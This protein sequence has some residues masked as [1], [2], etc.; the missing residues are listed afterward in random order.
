MKINKLSIIPLSLLILVTSCQKEE[1]E[2]VVEDPIEVCNSA[3]QEAYITEITPNN[4]QAYTN[5]IID[6]TPSQVWE[7]MTDF[8][9]M[10]DWSTTLQGI[11]GDVSNGGNA[12]IHFLNAGTVVDIPH[13]LIYEDGVMF[14][15]SEETSSAPGIFDH[16]IYKVE[17]CGDQT[18]FIQ[19]DQFVGENASTSPAELAEF[20]V[21]FY[22]IFNEDLKAEV[23]SRF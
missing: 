7:V 4:A 18:K 2:P 10:P 23:E 17:A 15:W 21:S 19:S 14:G 5:I 9:T 8:A 11:S 1:V 22:T 20:V 12:I 6:A 16:H 3:P 13:I